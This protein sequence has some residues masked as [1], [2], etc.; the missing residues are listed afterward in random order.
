VR[1]PVLLLA[2]AVVLTAI[3]V[4]TVVV[5]DPFAD[6][7]PADREDPFATT[8]LA[9]VDTTGLTVP[10]TSFCEA[11]DPREVEAALGAEPDATSGYANGDEVTLADGLT[12]VA[13][14]FGCAWSLDDGTAARAW[15]FAPPVDRTR[16]QRLV[17]DA[18]R[19]TGCESSPT[20]A[21][22]APSVATTCAA[23]G[24]TTVSYRGLF[25]DA[26]LVCELTSTGPTD[27]TQDDAALGERADAWCSG[28]A[29]G[30]S[31]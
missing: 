22:G 17:R 26:W 15:V 12:D 23:D 6:A 18:S 10:R 25:G 13:H 16:A 11:V 4:A 30:A 31:G 9:S 19:V 29:R 7:P 21:Y 1:R 3:A 24:R 20:P 28:V 8:P 14:E 5:L 2:A 27:V